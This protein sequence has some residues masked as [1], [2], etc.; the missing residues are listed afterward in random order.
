MTGCIA[1]VFPIIQSVILRCMYVLEREDG[2]GEG[3]SA[4]DSHKILG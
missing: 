1:H 2:F 3:N 4:G